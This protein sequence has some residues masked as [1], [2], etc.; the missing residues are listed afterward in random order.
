VRTFEDLEIE[1]AERTEREAAKEAKGKNKRGRKP[2]DPLPETKDATTSSGKCSKK[3]KAT[4]SSPD[5]LCT[6]RPAVP[7][8]VNGAYHTAVTNM[9]DCQRAPVA[10]MYWPVVSETVV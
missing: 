5:E 7:M 6:P 10:K 9:P 8:P 2:K 4:A 3:R 1:R